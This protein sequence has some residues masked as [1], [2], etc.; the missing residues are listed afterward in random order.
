MWRNNKM[1]RLEVIQFILIVAIVLLALFGPRANAANPLQTEI[2]G[3]YDYFK[4]LEGATVH[5]TYAPLPINDFYTLN[6]SVYISE[7]PTSDT[8]L[9]KSTGGESDVLLTPEGFIKYR[10][11]ADGWGVYKYVTTEHS[12]Q[13]N[14]WNFV[15]ISSFVYPSVTRI[16]LSIDRTAGYWAETMVTGDI[17]Q[18]YAIGN[19]LTDDIATIDY[20]EYV[21]DMYHT[22]WPEKCAGEILILDQ[23]QTG[24]VIF[25]KL[26]G[27]K[28]SPNIVER[29]IDG[30]L[31]EGWI[32][33]DD[34]TETGGSI[35]LSDNGFMFVDNNSVEPEPSV[36]KVYN[37]DN[38]DSAWLKFDIATPGNLE[39]GD[40]LAIDISYDGG[41]TWAVL[42]LFS[43]DITD[44]LLFPIS[45]YISEATAIRFRIDGGLSGTGENFT[46]QNIEIILE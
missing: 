4:G 19:Y 41:Q 1:K 46:L 28:P 40:V 26:A 15:L 24:S 32:E 6:F 11:K 39:N 45:D 27:P 36:Y 17:P 25:E 20:K 2:C 10:F 14:Q 7:L 13:L 16:T 31:A 18:D 44:S 34:G 9:V 35:T 42:Q 30:Y 37:L 38:F 3:E 29:L 33:A 8:L 43:N 12:I 21:G 5:G 22:K 23:Q